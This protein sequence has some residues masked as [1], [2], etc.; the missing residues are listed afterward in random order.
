[1]QAIPSLG[2]ALGLR[3][4]SRFRCDGYSAEGETA[5]PSAFAVG[6]SKGEIPT[7]SMLDFREK[8]GNVMSG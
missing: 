7:Y 3:Q 4:L 5:N 8:S 1:M 2:K 6:V